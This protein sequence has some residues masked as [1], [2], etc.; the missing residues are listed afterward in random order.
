MT[1]VGQLP[2]QQPKP[3]R[4]RKGFLDA[5]KVR[6]GAF[7]VVTLC[8]IA[9]VVACILAIWDFAERDTLW[10]TIATCVV[11]A[12]GC[13]TFSVVNLILGTSEDEN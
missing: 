8:I 1:N 12:A 6:A 4:K 5:N 11:I 3:K 2:H 13:A 7:Y 9:S 10:R